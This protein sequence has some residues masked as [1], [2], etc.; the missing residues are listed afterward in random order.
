MNVEQTFQLIDSLLPYE[1]CSYHQILPLAVQG[2]SLVL[3]MVHP[4]N[5]SVLDYVRPILKPKNYFIKRC[6]LDNKLYQDVLDK[7]IAQQQ[8]QHLQ[9]DYEDDSE[10]TEIHGK[11]TPKNNQEAHLKRKT[12]EASYS[13]PTPNAEDLT[14]K[15]QPLEVQTRYAAAS[16][17]ILAQLPPHELIPEL[18]GRSL[19]QNITQITFQREK[20]YGRIIWSRQNQSRIL[21]EKVPIPLFQGIIH[22]IK[23][24]T[25]LPVKAVERPRKVE[26]LR[27]YEH[28]PILLRIQFMPSQFGE[29]AAIQFFRGKLLQKYQKSQMDK[30]SQEILQVTNLL[31]QKLKNA[32]ARAQINPEQIVALP[33]L[34]QSFVKMNHYVN[35]IQ[36][37][38]IKY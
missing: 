6:T 1:I 33:A 10:P 5:V 19:I 4:E 8:Q 34:K 25:E 15:F 28:R 3:G 36:K 16:A 7:Y 38:Q 24:L 11:P 30:L 9:V 27:T 32:A 21:L 12:T 13:P 18:F 37:V 31:D 29:Q 23:R 20:S 17:I 22:E 14:S 26:M 2:E 35:Q